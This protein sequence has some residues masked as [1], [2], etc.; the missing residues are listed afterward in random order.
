MPRRARTGSRPERQA[1]ERLQKI[2][3]EAGVASR[4][5]AER[6]ILEGRVRVNGRVVRELGTRADFRRDRIE[7]DGRRVGR[8]RRR[9]AYVLYKPRGVVSTARDPHAARTVLDLIPGDER[10][11]PVG[12]LDAPS[13]GLLLVTNDGALAHALMHPSFEVPRIYRVSVA[14]S[15]RA[16]TLRILG[17]GVELEGRR[18]APC[19]VRMLERDE[20]HSVLEMRL[21]EGRKRQ[22]RQMLRAV[23]HPVRRLV[24]T[25]FGPVT[26][27][28]LRPGDWRPLRPAERAA[29]ERLG[30]QA[31]DV[32]KARPARKSRRKAG[33]R[34]VNIIK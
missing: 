1:G 25:A 5:A 12:R 27:A 29:L 17:R 10:L 22:I 14:G 34:K 4:R 21:V 11:Y 13:E 6:L 9:R 19:T 28:G 24:R 7:V 23:G 31:R 3:A 16:E 2:L 20:S 18:T 33:S 26:V 8:P 30:E 32:R 15:V